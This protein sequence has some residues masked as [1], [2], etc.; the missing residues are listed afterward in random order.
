VGLDRQKQQISYLSAYGVYTPKAHPRTT[1]PRNLAGRLS[2]HSPASLIVPGSSPSI[3]SS[4]EMCSR[5]NTCL[6]PSVNHKTDRKHVYR[7]AFHRR[8]QYTLH[9]GHQSPM[10]T[11]S[12]RFAQLRGKSHPWICQMRAKVASVRFRIKSVNFNVIHPLLS[13]LAPFNTPQSSR[14][15]LRFLNKLRIQLGAF[16]GIVSA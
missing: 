7:S 16:S 1:G 4:S 12:H 6:F 10:I 15:K 13:L 14:I 9:L 11:I 8:C 3:S 5:I 2:R